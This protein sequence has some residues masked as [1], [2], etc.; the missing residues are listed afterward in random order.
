[1]KRLMIKILKL[2]QLTPGS[3]HNQCRFTPTCSN[4]AIEA[5]ETYG[6]LKGGYLSIK[7]VLRCNPFHKMG[8]DP[9]PKKERT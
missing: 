1:M 7:R 9:V 3:F 5:I 2:Y 8:Y 4:Y 6:A